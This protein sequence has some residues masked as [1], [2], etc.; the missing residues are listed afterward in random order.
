M[1][2]IG[3]PV[4]NEE[5]TAG[6]LLWR[7]R[8]LLSEENREFHVIVVDDASSD[9][10]PEVLEPYSGLLPLTLRVNRERRGYGASMEQIAREAVS[11]TDYPRRDGLV[12][13][14]AD[15]TESPDLIPEMLRRFESGA[16]LVASRPESL[17]G[18]PRSVRIARRVAEFLLRGVSLP[19]DAGDPL[20][21]FRLYRLF[22]LERALSDAADEGPGNGG[23]QVP[24]DGGRRGAGQDE[25][26][27]PAHSGRLIRHDGWACN[28]ELLLRVLPH[29]RRL[30]E[31]EFVKDYGRRY[32]A[33]RFRPLPE[34]WE[35]WRT[36]RELPDREAGQGPASRREAS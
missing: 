3:L 7:I 26:D 8:K 19:E 25:Q 21:G 12:T 16:D 4:R 11:R 23:Q 31:M 28:V 34:L 24:G 36:V 20:S 6:V 22:V 9:A 1:I 10:T 2:Y 14:Q 18:A 32:R 35:L 5:H 27:R 17:R 33:S 15:F 13:L 30:E 29:A